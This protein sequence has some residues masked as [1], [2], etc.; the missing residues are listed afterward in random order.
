MKGPSQEQLV[1][2]T[3]SLENVVSI[4]KKGFLLIPNKRGLIRTLVPDGPFA[5]TEPQEFGMVSFA[6]IEP[7]KAT[8]HRAAF[9]DFGV[10]VTWEWAARH[11]AQRVIYLKQEG[12]VFEAFR[13]LFGMAKANLDRKIRFPENGMLTRAYTNRAM[14]GVQ[15]AAFWANLLTLYEYMEPAENS[16]QMEWRIV[17]KHPFTFS[18]RDKP[19]N[20][21]Q[22]LADAEKW[23][24]TRL[25]VTV[26]DV[27]FLICPTR[28]AKALRNALPKGFEQIDI[29]NHAARPS[30]LRHL[31]NWLRKTSGF[32]SKTPTNQP[33]RRKSIEDLPDVDRI[34]GASLEGQDPDVPETMKVVLQYADRAQ[35]LYQVHI[36]LLDAL[37]L[38]NILRA[39]EED[40]ALG[41]IN[42][43]ELG[44]NDGPI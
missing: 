13:S 30:V 42:N 41:Q 24:I 25:K 44:H 36:P 20:I 23:G 17:Q 12:P 37:Y 40:S 4:L 3:K 38:L 15:G 2:Y 5:D 21:A 43:P 19:S 32:R 16:S 8:E 28:H 18:E 11:Y 27:P 29:L 22:A 7:G 33:P 10:A 39:I 34:Q 31:R 6:E 9:G 35:N 14:A 1:H 26:E